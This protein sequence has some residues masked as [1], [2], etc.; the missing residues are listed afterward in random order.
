MAKDITRS[1][2]ELRAAALDEIPGFGY[3]FLQNIYQ[4]AQAGLPIN[5]VGS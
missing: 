4:F 1:C 5:E 3:D 2:H